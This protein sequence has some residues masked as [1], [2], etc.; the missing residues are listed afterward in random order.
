MNAVKRF[1][2]ITT[3]FPPTNAVKKFAKL[4]ARHLVVVGD[5]KTPKDWRQANA[6]FLSASQ[7]PRMP[8]RLLAALP[9][10]HYCRKMAGYL[11][12]M[13]NGAQ[14]IIDTDDDNEPYQDWSFPP[15]EGRQLTT[16]ANLGFVNLYRS[17]TPRHIWPRGFPLERIQDPKAILAESRLRAAASRVGVWQGLADG[18]PDV[19]AI[20]RVTCN[21]PCCFQ[22]RAPIV[23]DSGTLCP[24]NSQNTAFR[25]EVFPLLY[26]PVT[27]TF[28]FTDILRGLVAQPVLWAGGYRLGFSRATVV[29]KR[30]PHNYL[31][32]FESEIPC[33]LW[34]QRVVDVVRGVM[35]PN[36]GVSGNLWNAY[37]ALRREDM[38]QDSELPSLSAWLEDVASLQSQ[39][40]IHDA[41]S[42]CR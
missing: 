27:A 19:D 3:I 15:F 14:V 38:V 6:T 26:L 30:N 39:A 18:D 25:R 36:A 2:V 5:R 23:L 32:D 37:E 34:S 16:P 42:A 33:Y 22:K 17:F 9:W 41:R 20:Y 12:A 10:N 1:I 28:R 4:R 21:L 13:G 35:D 24:F 40:G 29:Q 31:K 7:Q 11:H 8:F